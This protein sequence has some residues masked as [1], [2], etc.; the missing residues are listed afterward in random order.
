MSWTG[1]ISRMG[2]LAD[3]VADLAEVPSRA[4]AAIAGDLEG[5][6]Q[7]EFDAGTDPYGQPWK[8]LAPAT[9]ARGRTAPPLTDTGAMR[10][11]AH[12]RPM[13]PAGVALSIDHPAAPH[14]TGWSGP[15]GTGPARPIL[16]ARSELPPD[17]QD[18]IA[19][20]VEAEFKRGAA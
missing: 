9:V 14:Q 3:R 19:D 13:R 15:Q 12:V 7:D 5:L 17:W 6:I 2:H 16:P 11:S 4:S 18:V 10:A 20:R 8:A 1:D